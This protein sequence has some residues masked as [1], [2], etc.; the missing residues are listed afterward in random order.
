MAR[1]KA[2]ERRSRARRRALQAVY[3]WQMTGLAPAEII[4]QFREQQDFSLV[5]EEYFE[6]LL[7]G[8]AGRSDELDQGL[9]AFVDRPVTQLDMMELAIIRLSGWELLHAPEV[10]YRVV[11]DEGI[12]LAHRFGAEQGHAFV[13]G[14]LDKAAKA[15][16]PVETG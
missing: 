7:K 6:K 4:L 9:G 11:L 8:V 16:R 5:D 10:P 3:Q 14:V 2:N 15:W 12:D 13:N 1:Q